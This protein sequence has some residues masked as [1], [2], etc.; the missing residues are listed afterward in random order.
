MCTAFC[1]APRNPI[2]RRKGERFRES[3]IYNGLDFSY[4]WS[5]AD[6]S[7]AKPKRRSTSFAQSGIFVF[8]VAF[9]FSAV[10]SQLWQPGSK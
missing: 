7:G 10:S 5:Q 2:S 1:R 6:S 8:R 4:F 9:D 3:S